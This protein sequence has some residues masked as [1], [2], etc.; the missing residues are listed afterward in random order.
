M[1]PTRAE[2]EAAIERLHTSGMSSRHR[3]TVV[4]RSLPTYC[5]SWCVWKKSQHTIIAHVIDGDGPS[6]EELSK[7]DA[8]L[9]T[10][11]AALEAHRA[12]LE[13]II[14]ASDQCKGHR[15]CGHSMEPWQR[16]RALLGDQ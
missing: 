5:H 1:T 12:V 16:A 7:F 2:V 10:L 4:L 9:A 15:D 13:A 14:F 11:T 3:R 8:D 6:D